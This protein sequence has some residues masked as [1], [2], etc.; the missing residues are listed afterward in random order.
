[1]KAKLIVVLA[2][3][4]LCLS[5]SG[6]S[7]ADSYST[8]GTW[9]DK[10]GDN[11]GS[12]YD[13]IL[14]SAVDG[15]ITGPG[16]YGLNRVHFIVGI[17]S[18][19]VDVLPGLLSQSLTVGAV[20]QTLIIPFSLDINYS[21]TLSI[22]GGTTLYFPGYK[23]VV[24]GL[25]LGPV[26]PYSGSQRGRLTAEVT[27]VPIPAALPLFAGSLSLLCWLARRRRVQLV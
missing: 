10:V 19:H 18:T 11:I 2:S 27:A 6:P 22:F 17:N 8:T 16:T 26:G 24:N 7:H 25:V 3:L 21:D 15:T 14:L 23:F 12:P 1:M 20:T 13:I 9:L 5:G 4:V